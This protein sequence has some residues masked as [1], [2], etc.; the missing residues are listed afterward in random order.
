M[1]LRVEGLGFTGFGYRASWPAKWRGRC[2]H[3][4]GLFHGLV[5]VAGLSGCLQF[6]C[7]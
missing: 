4:K 2:V 3:D 5:G 7:L 1:G 6:E